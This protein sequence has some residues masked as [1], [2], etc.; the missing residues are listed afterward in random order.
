MR[1]SI[2]KDYRSYYWH[3][4][5]LLALQRFAMVA[6]PIFVADTLKTSLLQAFIAFVMLLL[7]ISFEPHSNDDVNL[8]EK[9]SAVCLMA[10][11]LLDGP[12]SVLQ[13]AAVDI[14]S[15]NRKHLRVVCDAV[16]SIMCV[17]VL[18]PVL[19]V[20]CTM[21]LATAL[22][23]AK[24]RAAK[25]RSTTTNLLTRTRRRDAAAAPELNEQLLP[26]PAAAAA[27]DV[28]GAHA[29][30]AALQE[31]SLC[32]SNVV[33]YTVG[34]MVKN[35]GQSRISGEIV[36]LV[37]DSG[38]TG[39]GF[40]VVRVRQ[41]RHAGRRLEAEA[42]ARAREQVSQAMARQR[43]AAAGVTAAGG[44]G[45]SMRTS[46]VTKYAVGQRVVNMG[47]Q[48]VSGRIVRVV[49][50]GGGASGPGS[51]TIEPE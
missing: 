47:A 50:D 41:P 44:E 36:R 20:P 14:T 21:A 35:L 19:L 23:Q 30:A 32:T 28:G 27:G 17:F 4:P 38:S 10:L 16:E 42:A 2:C 31:A 43:A 3:W 48:R 46:N 13:Q 37:A 15:P 22:R 9:L 33:K 12:Q 11:A 5:A 18:A 7:Q 8:H 24:A 39:P 29:A 25:L 45:V 34:Q 26:N 1:E 49:A 6:T 40:M 51:L